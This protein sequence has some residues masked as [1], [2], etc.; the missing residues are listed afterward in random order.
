[1]LWLVVF[2]RSC[3]P[4]GKNWGDGS[5]GA[6][7]LWFCGAVRVFPKRLFLGKEEAIP[8]GLDRL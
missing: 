1:M 6:W 3:D 4:L 7:L 8:E 5:L 2:K